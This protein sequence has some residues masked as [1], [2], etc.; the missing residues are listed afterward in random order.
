MQHST[1]SSCLQPGCADALTVLLLVGKS[2]GACRDSPCTA[3]FLSLSSPCSQRCTGF[4]SAPLTLLR[5]SLQ[6]RR[7]RD[8]APPP[9]VTSC[10]PRGLFPG[11]ERMPGAGLAR[12]GLVL[13][14]GSWHWPSTPRL[15]EQGTGH[16]MGALLGNLQGWKIRFV[17]VSQGEE[18]DQCAASVSKSCLALASTYQPNHP[19]GGNHSLQK[20]FEH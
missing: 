8:T 12:T 10:L 1:R 13:H 7:L 14:Q 15:S 20:P 6:R 9:P 3:G 17:S 19:A 5:E 11:T 4:S 2:L 18:R 16:A